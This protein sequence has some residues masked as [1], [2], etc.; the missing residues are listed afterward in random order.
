VRILNVLSSMD[1]IAGGGITERVFQLSRN[2]IEKKHH[3]TILSTSHGWNQ[4]FINRIKGLEAV[5]IPCIS[6]R[7]MIP[8]LTKT[9]NWLSRNID[10]FDMLHLAGN[11]SPINVIA[12]KLARKF[13]I[14]YVFS[15]MGWL[16]IDGRS[17]LIKRFFRFLWTRPILRDAR[18]VIAISPR[19]VDDYSRL[20][21]KP[22]KIRFIPNG[23]STEELAS[24]DES[25][26]RN[27]YGLDDRKIVLFIGR[28][29]PIKG[30]DL[31]VEAYALIAR[32]FPEYQLLIF[33]NDHGG[34]QKK[35]EDRVR[36]LDL[37][38]CVK[39]FG[40]ILG[41]EKSW[42][43]HS[44]ELFVIPSRFD[45]MTIVALE[46]A[47]CGCPILLTDKCDFADMGKCGGGMVVSCTIENIANGL[48]KLLGDP[49]SL[50]QMGH[51]A[52]DFALANYSWDRIADEFIRVFQNV[53]LGR[54]ECTRGIKNLE[55][56]IEN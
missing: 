11:W 47:A 53:G 46:A 31:L 48:R 1:P 8:D 34:F 29:S 16:S 13:H 23:I 51:G 33:G 24:E 39:I 18:A 4:E 56:R 55:C 9:R 15:A 28:L 17:R 54:T 43:Y 6:D 7:Y 2:L 42:A 41:R 37:Q 21:V 40:P 25:A 12:Y 3:C 35:V 45:T 22:E 10:R 38:H 20:G 26:F 52:H 27:K 30:A 44:S 19:E 14:P 5:S 49:M 36:A 32:D 50:K